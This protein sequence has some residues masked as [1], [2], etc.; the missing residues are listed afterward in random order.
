MCKFL[1]RSSA[2]LLCCVLAGASVSYAQVPDDDAALRPAEPDYR[3]INLPTTLTVP[4]NR[5][6]FDLTHRF[7]GNLAR[8]S[9]GDNASNLFGLDQGATIGLEFRY[10]IAKHV[11]AAVYRTSFAKT[12]EL[13]GKWD[14]LAQRG[15]S[16]VSVSALVSVEGTDNFQDEHAPALGATV[17]RTFADRVALHAVPLWVHNSDG[18][19][20]V[21]RDTFLLGLG[22]RVR[23]LSTVYLVGEVSPRPAGY[24]PGKPEY[25]FGIEKRA[26]LHMFQLNFTNTHAS[27]PGQLARGGFPDSL[28]L[29][30]NLARKFF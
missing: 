20:G 6:N 1:A 15:R 22:A 3:L 24:D 7:N 28:Y 26:G 18:L 23:V 13:H 10:G 29:G 30:F 27:T 19:V 16:P 8:G 17:S 21:R 14:A 4:Q 11:Q 9:F 25:G 12:L 5:G 2:L